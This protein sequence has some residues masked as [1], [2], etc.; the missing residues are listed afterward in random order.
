MKIKILLLLMILSVI[1]C[2]TNSENEKP[3]TKAKIA[4]QWLLNGSKNYGKGFMAGDQKDLET[5][6]V[7]MDAYENMDAETMVEMSADTVRF[8]PADLAGVFK[9]DMTNT[10]FI[11][12]RQSNWDSISRDYIY[13][14]PLK[15]EGSKQ[16]SYDHVYRNTFHKGRY[17]RIY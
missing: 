2:S 4:G 16:R 15:I 9:I 3:I 11:V 10:D 6:K 13:L 7:F 17:P 8:H 12:E 1:S 5:V 14:M